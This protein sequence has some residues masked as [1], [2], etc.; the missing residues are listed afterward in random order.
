MPD[1]FS[2]TVVVVVQKNDH[3]LG[4]YELHSGDDEPQ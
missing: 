4:Y 1:N 2:E 3:P